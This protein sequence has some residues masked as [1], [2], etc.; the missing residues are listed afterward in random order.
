MTS[1][2]RWA[3]CLNGGARG[4]ANTSG[5]PTAQQW[6]AQLDSLIQQRKGCVFDPAMSDFGQLRECPWCRIENEGGASFFV[7]AETIATLAQRLDHLEVRLRQLSIPAFP[8]VNPSIWPRRKSWSPDRREGTKISQPDVAA[9]LMA[10]SVMLCLAG[11][12]LPPAVSPGP[13]WSAPWHQSP[14]ALSCIGQGKPVARPEFEGKNRWD[15]GTIRAFIPCAS[16]SPTRDGRRL[17]EL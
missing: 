14:A 11:I 10:S 1:R 15:A 17:P 13:C 9:G 4:R 2:R 16:T 6:T 12:L 5:R 7:S 8:G 3:S